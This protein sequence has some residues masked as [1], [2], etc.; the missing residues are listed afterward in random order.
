MT[1]HPDHGTA[2]KDTRELVDRYVALWNEPD[3]DVRRRTIRELWAPDGAQVLVDPPVEI[4]D[5]ADRLAFPHPTLEVHG[6]DAIEARVSRAYEMFIAPGEYVFELG[7][8]ASRLLGNVVSL[9]WSMVSR[10]D[11]DKAGGGLNV[12]ALGEDG[13]IRLD[14]Q[15]VEV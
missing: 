8:D 1:I 3:P 4:R 15:F 10:A 14:Y 9:T 11:R 7:G 5:A 2:V 12:L 6:Y 13:R